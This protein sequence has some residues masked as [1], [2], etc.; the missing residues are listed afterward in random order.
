[1]NTYFYVI[2]SAFEISN[3]RILKLKFSVFYLLFNGLLVNVRDLLFFQWLLSSGSEYN[4]TA[5]NICFIYIYIYIYI[6]S[7]CQCVYV[8]IPVCVCVLLVYLYAFIN[9]FIHIGVYTI[10]EYTNGCRLFSFHHAQTYISA[11][12]LIQS[13]VN[14]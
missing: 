8:Y 14:L 1:M 7:V 13:T 5:I 4:N 3:Q 2:N 10:K 6:W 9:C 12:S 11:F